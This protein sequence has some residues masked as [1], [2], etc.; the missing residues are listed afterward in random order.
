[1]NRKAAVFHWMI[2]GIVAAIA[3]FYILTIEPA[4]NNNYY[5]MWH[6]GFI[7]TFQDAQLEQLESDNHIREIA[8][9]VRLGLPNSLPEDFGC[10]VINEVPL[11]NDGARFCNVFLQNIFL[12]SF[13]EA[14]GTE[15]AKYSDIKL[16][17]MDVVGINKNNEVLVQGTGSPVPQAGGRALVPAFERKYEYNPSFRIN[18]G[19]KLD[20]FQQFQI[21][22]GPLLGECRGKEDLRTCINNYD[23]PE[24]WHRFHDCYN[25]IEPQDNKVSFC[26]GIN[27]QLYNFALDFNEY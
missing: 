27:G 22:A 9:N 6:L 7:W 14:L 21:K 1:M 10:G 2:F 24:G 3:I 26:V 4:Q 12:D 5:G 13:K 15:A 18:L 25:D 19:T 17:G 23:L 11:L 8:Y 16:S 20:E